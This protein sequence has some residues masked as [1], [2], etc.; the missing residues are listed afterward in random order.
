MGG[1]YAG[2][3]LA[4]ALATKIKN[5]GQQEGKGKENSQISITL[6]T[7]TDTILPV[8]PISQRRAAEQQLSRNG[9]FVK[10]GI[11]HLASLITHLQVSW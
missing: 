10:T 4:A 11:V 1:G 2:V 7:D 8:A 6:I 5:L 3:E 9:V